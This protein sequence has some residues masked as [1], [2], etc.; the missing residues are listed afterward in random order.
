MRQKIPNTI[1]ALTETYMYGICQFDQ[2]RMMRKME[3]QLRNCVYQIILCA[4][5]GGIFL[6]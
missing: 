6:I 2:T 3:N 4:Y 5:L 1:G